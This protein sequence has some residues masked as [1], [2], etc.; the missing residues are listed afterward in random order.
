MRIRAVMIAA[1]IGLVPVVLMALI[2]Y[3]LFGAIGAYVCAGIVPLSFFMEY[4]LEQMA[5]KL[6]LHRRQEE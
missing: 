3:V 2:G 4:G 6:V 1:L 5:L